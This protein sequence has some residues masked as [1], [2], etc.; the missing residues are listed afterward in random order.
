[1]LVERPDSPRVNDLSVEPSLRRWDVTVALSSEALAPPSSQMR[2]PAAGPAL[3]EGEARRVSFDELLSAPGDFAVAQV[4]D[5]SQLERLA[6]AVDAGSGAALAFVPAHVSEEARRAALVAAPSMSLVSVD[7]PPA[8]VRE[9][10]SRLAELSV[11]RCVMGRARSLVRAEWYAHSATVDEL[12]PAWPVD[13]PSMAV[14]PVASLD[15]TVNAHVHAMAGLWWQGP[16]K[17]A[18]RLGVAHSTCRRILGAWPASLRRALE[19]VPKEPVRLLIVDDDATFSDV[20]ARRVEMLA[21]RGGA[22]VRVRVVSSA[23]EARAVIVREGA[24][25]VACIDLRLETPTSGL[26]LLS[27]VRRARLPTIVVGKTALASAGDTERFLRGGALCVWSMDA[28]GHARATRSI[29]SVFRRVWTA[30]QAARGRVRLASVMVRLSADAH[31]AMPLGVG[32][33]DVTLAQIEHRAAVLAM[34]MCDGQPVAAA[35]ALGISPRRLQRLI[36]AG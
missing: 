17:V 36:G 3:V 29:E 34:Q 9:E 12:L 23:S 7:G 8:S 20:L 35:R 11:R 1:M 32:D 6:M 25:E 22:S 5:A 24:P 33:R 28:A 15:A 18:L 10:A 30:L 31:A 4:S 14:D 13:P 21:E 16:A 26:E 19:P 2:W 27:W